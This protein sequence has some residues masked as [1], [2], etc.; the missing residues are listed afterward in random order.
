MKTIGNKIMAMLLIALGVL[1]AMW[2]EGDCTVLLLF[3]MVGIGLFFEKKSIFN[4]YK[5]EP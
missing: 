5:E 3:G 2:N 1:F 4:E